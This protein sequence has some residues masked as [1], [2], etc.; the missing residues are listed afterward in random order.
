MIDDISVYMNSKQ[1][2]EDIYQVS[3][4]YVWERK[5]KITFECSLLLECIILLCEIWVYEVKLDSFDSK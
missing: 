1:L 2:H 4:K 3:L 5:R